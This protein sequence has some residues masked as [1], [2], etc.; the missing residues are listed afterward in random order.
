MQGLQGLQGAP[1]APGSQGP[2]GSQGLPGQQGMQGQEGP[3]GPRGD[4]GPQG[5]PGQPVNI[6]AI[7]ILPSVHRYFYVVEEDVDLIAGVQIA[8][9]RFV[10]DAGEPAHAF[11]EHGVQGYN[12]LYIN[13]MLQ[14]RLVYS[15]RPHVLIIHPITH[16]LQAGTPLI[17]ES[18]GFRAKIVS[19]D[20]VGIEAQI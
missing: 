14:E 20:P 7:Q 11:I 19:D 12:N 2:L 16:T 10:N 1:G 9:N 5:V 13:A 3:Q 15:V 18:V 8:A 17:V 6:A 4:R